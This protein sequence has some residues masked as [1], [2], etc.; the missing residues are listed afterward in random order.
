[1]AEENSE[2]DSKVSEINEFEVV[3]EVAESF[4]KLPDEIIEKYS[5]RQIKEIYAAIQKR[6]I[7]EGNRLYNI[8]R[9]AVGSL[10]KDQPPDELFVIDEEND[11]NGKPK[12][13]SYASIGLASDSEIENPNIRVYYS[14]TEGDSKDGV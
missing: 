7:K 1:M 11:E 14:E 4:R 8:F 3:V 6:R 13:K 5:P 10:F 2:H 12:K 9:F